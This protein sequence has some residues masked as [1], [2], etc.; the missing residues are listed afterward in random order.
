M[1]KILSCILLLAI[2]T[3]LSACGGNSTSDKSS[4]NILSSSVCSIY[5]ESNNTSHIMQCTYDDTGEDIKHGMLVGESY[6]WVGDQLYSC[7][8]DENQIYK[9]HIN[10]DN[11][12]E[13]EV[14]ISNE[15]IEN[16]SLNSDGL[17][18]LSVSNTSSWCN[19]GEYIYFIYCPTKEYL[20]ASEHNAFRII[21]VSIDK[22]QL[23]FVG[24]ATA[25]SMALVDGWIYYFD[26]GY[27]YTDSD[28]VTN[29]N[30]V[31]LYKMKADGSEKTLI[32]GGFEAGEYTYNYC[33][34]FVVY[35]KSIYF[36]DGSTKGKS[37]VCKL[38]TQTSSIEYL[39]QGSAFSFD[40]GDNAIY[41]ANGI[42]DK[43]TTGGRD[44]YCLNLS[45]MTETKII[46][47]APQFNNIHLD[48]IESY[49]YVS[50]YNLYSNFYDSTKDTPC[51]L[52][53]RFDVNTLSPESLFGYAE[54]ETETKII[55]GRGTSQIQE[56]IISREFFSYWETDNSYVN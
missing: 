42:L 4:M 49:L 39:T 17:V 1:K 19:D 14:W 21:R 20:Y 56:E 29:Y 52:A 44:I 7:I 27:T 55:S 23:E 50:S 31:G 40:V 22:A 35:D 24:D 5:I 30:R 47:L 45:D 10:N 46:S 54:V 16:S 3:T 48:V 38:D 51:V 33:S 6:T 37:R 28:Y 18:V 34:D 9:S 8:A 15:A 25:E 12:F 11:I 2:I 26:N 13:D 36:I 53:K 43:L 41:Y 32:K